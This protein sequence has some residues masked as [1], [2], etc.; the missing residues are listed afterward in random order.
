[1]TERPEDKIKLKLQETSY[2]LQQ[3]LEGAGKIK[4][5]GLCGSCARLRYR[6]S[7]YGSE[8]GYCRAF[9][10][11][12]NPEDPIVVCSEYWPKGHPGLDSMIENAT[13]ITVKHYDNEGLYL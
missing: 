2:G 6:A 9:E 10:K 4:V 3:R 12:I 8:E 13:L 7:K 11:S 1:M 5:R